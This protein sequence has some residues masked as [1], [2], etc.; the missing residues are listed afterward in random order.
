MLIFQTAKYW[1]FISALKEKFGTNKFF[2]TC[3]IDEEMGN[4]R[5]SIL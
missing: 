5:F 1:K 3:T 2:Y 4:K